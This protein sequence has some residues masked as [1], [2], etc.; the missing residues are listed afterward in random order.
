MSMENELGVIAALVR[1]RAAVRVRLD[2]SEHGLAGQS[3][4]A[5]SSVNGADP[6]KSRKCATI[7]CFGP[8]AR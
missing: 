4:R 2:D 8:H 6:H 5:W 7:T 3:R 1:E